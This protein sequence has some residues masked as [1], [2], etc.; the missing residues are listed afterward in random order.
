MLPACMADRFFRD[1]TPNLPDGASA[2]NDTGSVAWLA[3]LS[4]NNLRRFADGYPFKTL[5]R[6]NRKTAQ[7]RIADV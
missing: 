6:D 1:A 2:A 4:A 5:V 7:E 3:D